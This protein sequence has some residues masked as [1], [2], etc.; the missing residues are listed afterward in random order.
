[1][2]FFKLI[3]VLLALNFISSVHAGSVDAMDAGKAWET[4]RTRTVSPAK[5]P[6]KRSAF[7]GWA[8][9]KV[10]K[11]GFFR[12]TQ[13]GR[14][15]WLVDPEGYLFFSMGVNSV[16]PKRVEATDLSA[17]SKDTSEI[18]QAAGFNTL[19]RWSKP[20][21][22][23]ENNLATPYCAT[24]GFVQEYL[25]RYHA[26]HG[27]ERHLYQTVPVFDEDWDSFCKSYAEEE[28][29]R[30]IDDRYLIGYFS[31]NELD[32][33]PDALSKYL[34]LP[35]DDP[36]YIGAK[37][38]LEE[39]NIGNSRIT[40]SKVEAKF[41]EFV[42]RKY[43]ETVSKYLKKFDP[44]HL[45]L[46][47]RLHGRAISEPVLKAS[48]SC[49]VVSINLYHRWEPDPKATAKFT[50]W[51]TRPFL[52][53]EF[54]AMKIAK[55][56]TKGDGAGFWVLSHEGAGEFYQTFTSTLLKK[57]PNCV[58]FHWFK[59]ADDTD[60]YQKGIV[61]KTGEPHTILLEAMA[62]LNQQAY[63]LRGK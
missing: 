19:G 51:S 37:A 7:G 25:R 12:L 62:P 55:K 44:N 52:V 22:F 21:T 48:E 54:Y 39:N 23:E 49:D 5:T 45:Y 3:T 20:Q 36:G 28:A 56:T 18:L 29:A 1:M 53:G 41:L 63:S 26:K 33:R 15:W 24:L 38:W 30:Y 10:E 27:A 60:K 35:N 58:G 9:H 40:D 61:S 57:H 6:D 16:D 50:E 14:K 4:F 8:D 59:Y 43:F 11:P 13:R 32:F 2:P 47:S 42:A 34:E 31:D 46:G 17:W